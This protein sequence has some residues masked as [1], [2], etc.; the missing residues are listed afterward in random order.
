MSKG[1]GWP[2]VGTLRRGEVKE[3]KEKYSY[4]TLEKGVEIMVDGKVLPM[5]EKRQIR[6]EDPR[7]KVQELL[8]KGIIDDATAERRLESLAENEWLRYELVLPPPRG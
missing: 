5:N 2:K 7:K 8:D 6:L 4:I 1:K 3:T